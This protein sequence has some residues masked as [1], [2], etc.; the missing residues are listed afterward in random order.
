MAE[1]RIEYMAIEDLLPD[2]RNPKRHRLDLIDGSYDEFGYVEPVTLDERTGMLLAGHGRV[3]QLAGRRLDGKEPPEGVKVREDGAW[4][5]PVVRGVATRDDEH[6][7]AYL[8][9]S[10][11]ISEKGGWDLPA[12]VALNELPE[13]PPLMELAGFSLP[14]LLDMA[15]PAEPEAPAAFPGIDPNTLAVEYCCPKCGYE[16]S[17]RADPGGD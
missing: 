17:G 5:L 7:A 13:M 9:A 15:G 3:E 1:H 8:V 14:E 11:R 4:T 16:W 2:L 10:N 12:L 6:A